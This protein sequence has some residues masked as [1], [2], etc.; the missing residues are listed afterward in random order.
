MLFVC[1]HTESSDAEKHYKIL[2]PCVLK[3][4]KA[5]KCLR[6]FIYPVL[7]YNKVCLAKYMHSGRFYGHV[8]S[9]GIRM[10]VTSDTTVDGIIVTGL[11]IRRSNRNNLGR[12]FSNSPLK[13]IL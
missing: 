4:M 10:S 13:H 8:K 9:T 5:I 2:F 12:I 3:D 11:E 1:S 7:S 6:Y